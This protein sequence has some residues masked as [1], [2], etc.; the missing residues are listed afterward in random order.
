MAQ[1]TTGSKKERLGREAAR[2]QGAY[3]AVDLD[4][5]RPWNMRSAG[6][7]NA[8][9]KDTALLI[10]RQLECLEVAARLWQLAGRRCHLVLFGSVNSE[11]GTVAELNVTCKI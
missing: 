2:G 10:V 5:K 1:R 9:E 4:A 3:C 11:G 8:C 7:P 6:T